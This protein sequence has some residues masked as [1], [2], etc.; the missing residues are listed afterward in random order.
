MTTT[1]LPII[2]KKSYISSKNLDRKVRVE[3]FLPQNY[4]NFS[5]LQTLFLNDGQDYNQLDLLRIL[6][7]HNEKHADA[8][9]AVIALW[10]NQKRIYE[11]GTIGWPDYE[12][13]GD[14]AGDYSEFI[15]HEVIPKYKNL[16]PQL[17]H[18]TKTY[19]AGFS[20]GGLS[21]FDLTWEFPEIFSKVG[22]FSGSF[23][24][25][26]K[27]YEDGYEEDHDRIVHQK[28]KAT[29]NPDLEL[30]FWFECGTNDETSD[31]NNSGIIDSIE[32]TLDLIIELKAKGYEEIDNIVYHEIM[33][34]EHNFDTWKKVFP[35][36]LKWLY[37]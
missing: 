8:P 36:F 35:E 1:P 11:Y 31:R 15:R 9:L 16:Y 29:E 21:A 14:L 25:R 6:E 28:V 34:G 32:D 20:L 3:V 30:K 27:A 23:W 18:P 24:W 13:R 4:L 10:A 12:N 26:S 17:I 33:D 2:H 37:L 19:F 5:V 22:V 7:E